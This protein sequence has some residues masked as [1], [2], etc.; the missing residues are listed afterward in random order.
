MEAFKSPSLATK[1][2]DRAIEVTQDLT[3]TVLP[4]STVHV[5]RCP[6]QEL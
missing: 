4:T 2:S 5:R 3:G 1:E 6:W